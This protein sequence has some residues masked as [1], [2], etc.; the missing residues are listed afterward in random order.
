ME[1]AFV[2]FRG[3][4]DL[5]A[6]LEAAASLVVMVDSRGRIAYVSRRAGAAL[7]YEPGDLLGRAVEVLVP[8]E[9]RVSHVPVREVYLRD[10]T[11]RPM[12]IGLDLEVQRRDGSRFPVEIGLTH[13]DRGAESWTIAALVDVTVRRAHEAALSASSRAYRTLARLNEAIVR[14]N[15]VQ[16][17]YAD[18]CRVAVEDGGYLGAWVLLPSPAGPVTVAASA[19][20]TEEFVSRLAGLADPDDANGVGLTAHA[21][22]EGRAYYGPDREEGVETGPW[23]A[24]AAE[25]GIRAGASIPLR[26]GGVTVG[27]LSLISDRADVFDAETRVLLDGLADNVSFAL[28][29]FASSAQLAQTA[30]ERAVLLDRLVHAQQEERARIAA[31]VHDDSVQALAAVDLRLALLLGRAEA[32]APALGPDVVALQSMVEQVV[33]GLRLLL[34]E[35]EPADPH[36]SLP[37]LLEDAAR[38]VFEGTSVRWSVDLV[39]DAACPLEEHEAATRLPLVTRRQVARVVKEALIN[40]RKHAG[41]DVVHVGV[42]PDAEGLEVEV[43]DDG[44]GLSGVDLASRPGHRGIATMRDRVETSNGWFRVERGTTGTTIRFWVPRTPPGELTDA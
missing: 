44:V 17:L 43:S 22:R 24:L 1:H 38:N 33:T 37:D 35:L 8:A 30:Q 32:A 26:C 3:D 31:D 19:G 25:V 29:G 34:F 18:T 28:D 39:L 36:L 40:V 16:Q 4:D 5:V 27:V 41:A 10:A 11:T 12:G 6:V 14:A 9:R 21:L 20:A 13:L 15:D 42:V 2:P 7:G 23:D